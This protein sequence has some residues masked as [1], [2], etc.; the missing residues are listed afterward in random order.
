MQPGEPG[1]DDAGMPPTVDG[2]RPPGPGADAG[3]AGMAG[4]P[5]TMEGGRGGMMRPMPGDRPDGGPRPPRGP[6]RDGGR[7]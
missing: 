3:T 5:G 2:G 7:P 1:E 6:M 4:M